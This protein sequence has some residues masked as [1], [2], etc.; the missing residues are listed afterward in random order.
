MF[1]IVSDI[2]ANLEALEASP[3]NGFPESHA[4]ALR[5]WFFEQRLRLSMPDDVE[6]SA[7]RLGFGSAAALDSALQRERS[8]L[9][10][11]RRAESA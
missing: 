5:L 8:F 10:I 1:A 4:I 3:K 6:D 2:H 11:G 7:R 9:E